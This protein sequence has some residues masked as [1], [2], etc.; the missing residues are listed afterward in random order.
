MRSSFIWTEFS[1]VAHAAV[2]EGEPSNII[3]VLKR[4]LKHI[5]RLKEPAPKGW[6]CYQIAAAYDSCKRL[7][8]A[9]I[10]YREA[11]KHYRKC[12][13]P[14]ADFL[15]LRLG[16]TLQ[17]INRYSSAA[18]VYSAE[19]E[20]ENGKDK[21]NPDL[22][23]DYLI[24][25]SDCLWKAR[26]YG[27]SVELLR[28]CLKLSANNDISISRLARLLFSISL[29]SESQ[30]GSRFAIRLRRMAKSIQSKLETKKAKLKPVRTKRGQESDLYFNVPIE[31]PYRW[32]E[33]TRSTLVKA[34]ISRQ[35]K[36]SDVYLDSLPAR[37]SLINWA[38]EF[39]YESHSLMP[40]KQGRSFY[41]YDS[42]GSSGP[43]LLRAAAVNGKRTLIFDSNTLP[44]GQVVTNFHLSPNGRLLAYFVSI[45]GSESL[46]IKVRSI[47]SG[48]DLPTKLVGLRYLSLLWSENSE[49]FYYSYYLKQTNR[50][51][52]RYHYVDRRKDILLYEN[53]SAGE[54]LYLMLIV[55]KKYL[56]IHS[57]ERDRCTVQIR[58]ISSRGRFRTVLTTSSSSNYFSPFGERN[59]K[60]YFLTNDSAQRNRILSVDFSN[61][62]KSP[63]EKEEVP[64]G[65][66]VL[67]R[68]FLCKNILVCL[69]RYKEGF[70][71]KRL[72]NGRLLGITK[73][74]VHRF[75]YD[76]NLVEYPYVWIKIGGQLAPFTLYTFNV[77]SGALRKCRAKSSLSGLENFATTLLW[78]TSKDGT[79][80]PVYVT[81]KKGISLNGDHP[82]LLTGY[83]GF[84]ISTELSYNYS[85]LSWLRNDGILAYAVI[86]G[87]GE[88]GRTWHQ[89]GRRGNKQNCFDDFIAA[90]EM[91]IADKY[92]RPSKLGIYGFSN[93]G[94]LIGAVLAQRPELFGAAVIFTAVLDMIRYHRF[95]EAKSW[96]SE[97]GVS[98]NKRDFAILHS[99]SP[100]HNL[101]PAAYPPTLI[102]TGADDDLVSPA[103]SYKFAAR[104]QAVQRGAALIL[105]KVEKNSG[106][107]LHPNST[108]WYDMLSFFAHY[109][110][111][112]MTLE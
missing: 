9:S 79:R 109:L 77:E 52:I 27:Q 38:H 91:L 96:R 44:G 101:K 64:D 55:Q 69:Y 73:L 83:G 49:G 22:H 88:Y 74:P 100:L 92:T 16:W 8:E 31:D 99:Y 87:G 84:N 29:A 102:F 111:L 26:R 76:A 30:T 34:W 20:L 60:I 82:T 28:K 104:L 17:R 75:F 58:P 23:F 106:H 21:T 85:E 89:Q 105:L 107:S 80:I 32:L 57:G 81:A 45:S 110:G 3:K 12:D 47:R 36:R 108:Y 2:L 41:F 46:E 39:Y 63:L 72:R 94:L 13:K 42:S 59:G 1:K 97:Y 15:V 93:G 48:A 35:N 33:K 61:N 66:S 71:I 56:L 86:R 78:A 19:A 10:F 112:Q 24:S 50:Y 53:K 65:D 95:K 70:L 62:W 68:A 5:R 43:C 103:H 51:Q 40:H 6:T 11:L 18:R 90:A 54:S 7:N 67:N 14:W 37:T 25:A 98:T 4:N